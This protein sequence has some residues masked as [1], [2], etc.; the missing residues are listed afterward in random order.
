MK[1][2]LISHRSSRR[3]LPDFCRCGAMLSRKDANAGCVV[4]AKCAAKMQSH[5]RNMIEG[6][7][8]RFAEAAHRDEGD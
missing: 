2:A 7:A 1:T 3:M 8:I 4:C 6:G 5:M